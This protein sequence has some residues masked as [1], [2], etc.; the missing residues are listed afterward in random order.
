M[1]IGKLAKLSGATP[2]A[3]RLYESIG[4]IPTPARLG[5]YR[6]YTNEDVS[7]V[8]MIRRAQAVGFSL[9]DLKDLANAKSSTGKLSLE[10]A[11]RMI[12]DK[13][14]K[15]RKQIDDTLK[16]DQQLLELHEELN[17]TYGQVF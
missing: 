5:R 8:H 9:A 4:L 6:I 1:Y 16:Q 13:R 17:R 10:I 3:I 2:K 14:E 15:L 12:A 11:N 7:L